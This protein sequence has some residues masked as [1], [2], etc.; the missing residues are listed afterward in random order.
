MV[1][2]RAF[3][4]TDIGLLPADWD[5]VPVADLLK[6]HNGVNADKTSYGAGVPFINVLEVIT[7]SHLHAAD[8]PGRISLS[9]RAIDSYL[10]RRG[11]VVFN[12]TSETQEE[13]GLAAVYADDEEVVFGGFVIR[14]R[15]TSDADLDDR[16]SG[17]ALRSPYI[18]R[19]IIA[20]GQ[21]AIRANV[22]Q[23]DLRTVLVPRP[24]RREQ[25]AIAQA[26]T[27]AE[28][29][30]ESLRHLLAKKRQL[31]QGTMQQL[32]SGKR[33]LPDFSEAWEVKRLGD[34]FA[35]VN[36]RNAELNDNGGCPGGC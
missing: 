16:F 35:L 22:G 34:C 31:K 2:N 26:L 19:Q 25:E 18:R 29:L 13:V 7:K 33:R 21:G 36:T 11:D 24:P 12:R 10:V 6:L 5:L 32:L 23:N 9:R 15:Q 4:Q 30:I 14:G 20:R 1:V 17:Y 27:D 3:M 28:A 8:I